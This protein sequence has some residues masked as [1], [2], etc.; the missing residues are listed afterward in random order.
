MTK[1]RTIKSMS[2]E[3]AWI[4]RDCFFS[5][6]K[7]PSDTGAK[8]EHATSSFES[9]RVSYG[10]WDFALVPQKRKE[11]WTYNKTDAHVDLPSILYSIVADKITRTRK[12]S[13][14]IAAVWHGIDIRAE[15]MTLIQV[16]Q[17]SYPNPL[18]SNTLS[19]AA[20]QRAAYNCR[21]VLVPPF[22]L[23]DDDVSWE[24]FRSPY[25]CNVGSV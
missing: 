16:M 9:E 8:I 20:K 17:S 14:C 23:C 2:K 7:R 25:R 22:N 19:D 12:K 13:L 18:C 1:V 6:A 15:P 24:V 10:K 3:Q 11:S 21:G 4:L 5:P